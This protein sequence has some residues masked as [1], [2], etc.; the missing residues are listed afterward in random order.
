[1][2]LFENLG[3]S[4]PLTKSLRE[5]GFESPTP[6]QEQAIPQL[7]ASKT[8]LIGLAQTGTGKT[9]AFGLPLIDLV[10]TENRDTKA[11]VL[12][13][14]RELVLQIVQ[15]LENFAKYF[16]QLKIVAVYGGASIQEQIR[17]LKAGAHIV[18]A[19][20]GRLMDL[21]DRKAVRPDNLEYLVLDE[22]DEMLNMGF[23][24]DIDKILT[25][26]PEEKNVWLFSATMPNEIRHI[27][28]TYMENPIEVKVGNKNKTNENIDHQYAYIHHKH[29][30]AALKRV[31]D[32]NPEVF[33]VIFCRT[34]KNTQEVAEN[35][36]KDGYNAD[37]LHGDLSQAQRDKVMKS[38]RN[39]SLQLLV[40]TD[41][42][43]RGI[44]VDDI[45]HVFH[46]DLPDETEFYTHR[47]GR[48]ARIGKKGISIAF[49]GK[50]DLQKIFQMEKQLNTTFTKIP[51][52][53]GK[54]VCE[55]QLFHLIHKLNKVEINEDEIQRFLPSVL[56]EL[57]GLDKSE[58]I[59]R[60]VTLEFNRFFEYYRFAPDLNKTDQPK[61]TRSKE[62]GSKTDR[63]FINLGKKDGLDKGGFLA[64]MDEAYQVDGSN[65]GRID[66]NGAYSFFEVS[67]MQTERLLAIASDIDFNGRRVKMEVSGD[68]PMRNTRNN[69]KGRDRDN[70]GGGGS[71]SKNKFDKDKNGKSSSSHHKRKR[72]NAY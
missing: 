50:R 42:A 38:F 4:Q 2:S 47:S 59:K 8:D 70:K 69:S 22:A 6:I 26:T 62:R 12:A 65:I 48:T 41:V 28:Q 9:A 67:S 52:P 44:D 1:M 35:L 58:I 33:G 37:A 54:D 36:I 18:V 63:L 64:F 17:K 7:I 60:F 11:L 20:P 40:A 51:V 27:C 31:I 25:F 29:K 45:T 71:Y 19:T 15:N 72:A 55:Q 3:L 16:P 57:N 56:E 32:V 68:R 21:L 23:R 53:T 10:S 34:K 46:L 49:V 5:L 24:D 39:R 61:G 43:A 66:M 14:T 30:Y 13:P